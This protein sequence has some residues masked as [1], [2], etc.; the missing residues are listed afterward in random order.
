[1][2]KRVLWALSLIAILC[3]VGCGSERPYDLS[4]SASV[5]LH[6]YNNDSAAPFIKISMTS[7]ETETIVEPA[8]PLRGIACTGQSGSQCQHNDCY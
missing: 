5:E 1:M 7:E 8:P 6:A 2:K 3:L 4:G